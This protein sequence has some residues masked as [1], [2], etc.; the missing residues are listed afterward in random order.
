MFYHGINW[1]YV[2]REYP[3]LSP[4]RTVGGKRRD[5]LLDRLHLVQQFGLEPIHLLEA[6]E[7]YPPERCIQACLAFGDTVF[8]FAQ[9]PH[10]IWQLSA[11]EVGVEVL[12]LR[13]CNHIFTNMNNPETAEF[14]P[15]TPC[16]QLNGRQGFPKSIDFTPKSTL[17]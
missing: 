17:L 5:Q 16:T 15:G 10:P 8:A 4:R 2:K 6:D 7:N 14:F 3:L 1:V 11:H 13:T 12:D 9:L